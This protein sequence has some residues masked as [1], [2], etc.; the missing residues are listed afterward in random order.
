[1]L[2]LII[3]YATNNAFSKNIYG[4]NLPSFEIMHV[5]KITFFKVISSGKLSSM[6]IN[7]LI[8]SKFLMPLISLSFS[9]TLSI[10]SFSPCLIL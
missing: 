9:I 7:I 2:I 5:I 1:M 6:S 3:F 4:W 8:S 10:I